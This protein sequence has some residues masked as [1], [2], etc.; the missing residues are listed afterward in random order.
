MLKFLYGATPA[1]FKSAYGLEESVG[2][3]QA[4]TSRSFFGS[5][6]KQTAAGKVSA[7][8]VR[9][10]RVIPMVSNSFK[11]FFFGRFEQ[12]GADV[13]SPAASR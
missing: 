9:L 2:R 4:A 11:P 13:L 3:L 7:S 6:S 1:E 12:R 5:M 8:T 10:Q